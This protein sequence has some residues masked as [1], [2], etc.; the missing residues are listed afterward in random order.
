MMYLDL[1]LHLLLVLSRC[2]VAQLLHLLLSLVDAGVRLQHRV[3]MSQ[4]SGAEI[5][6]TS[7]R[8]SMP[9]SN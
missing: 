7:Q 2:L 9:C 8:P 5:I 1:V 3:S 4:S 6:Q